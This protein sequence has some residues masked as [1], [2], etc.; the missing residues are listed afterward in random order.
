[1]WPQKQPMWP[2]D[3]EANRM[4]N[5][6]VGKIESPQTQCLRAFPGGD[7]GIRTH[8]GLHPN[9]FQAIFSSVGSPN[10]LRFQAFYVSP[11]SVITSFW[12]ASVIFS[13]SCMQNRL[14]KMRYPASKVIRKLIITPSTSVISLNIWG[15]IWGHIRSNGITLI[16][17]PNRAS[18]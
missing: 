15:H 13:Q 6:K 5:R 8:V 9:G 14:W 18:S 2:Q 16:M 11:K 7:G 10:L 17:T 4:I 12:V 1:M 3:F